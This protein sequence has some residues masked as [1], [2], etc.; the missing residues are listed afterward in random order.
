MVYSILSLGF[1]Q[2]DLIFSKV[3]GLVSSQLHSVYVDVCGT[4]ILCLLGSF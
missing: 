1:G 3:G 2:I 4:G